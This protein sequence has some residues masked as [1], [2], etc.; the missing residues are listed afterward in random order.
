MRLIERLR[1]RDSSVYQT[2]VSLDFSTHANPNPSQVSSGIGLTF[3]LPF[4]IALAIALRLPDD[5]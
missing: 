3:P 1:F 5:I 2:T 4:A